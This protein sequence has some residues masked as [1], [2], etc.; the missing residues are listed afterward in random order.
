MKPEDRSN[1]VTIASANINYLSAL[2]RQLEELRDEECEDEYGTLRASQHA[3]EQA[4]DLLTNAAIH[5]ALKGDRQIPYGCASTDSEGGIRIEWVRPTAGVHLV[6]PANV[7]GDKYVYH[8]QGDHYGTEP[9]TAEAIAR[10]LS[11]LSDE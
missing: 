5:M 3:F 2:I 1:Y 4:R 10:W 11:I 7:E 8:E 6:I 9:A